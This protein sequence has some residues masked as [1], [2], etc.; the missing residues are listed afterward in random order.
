MAVTPTTSR[1]RAE[2]LAIRRSAPE[3][4]KLLLIDAIVP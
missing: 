3:H 4:A 1:Q 2:I